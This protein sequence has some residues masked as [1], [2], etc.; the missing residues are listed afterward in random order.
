MIEVNNDISPP[1][2][3][4]RASCPPFRDRTGW[5]AQP[6]APPRPSALHGVPGVVG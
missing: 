3:V 6:H 4:G 2:S 5:R 1:I